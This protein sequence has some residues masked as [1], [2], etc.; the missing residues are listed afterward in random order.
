MIDKIIAILDPLSSPA[1][2]AET[3]RDKGLRTIAA[4]TVDLSPEVLSTFYKPQLFD[5]AVNTHG[6]AEEDV[7]DIITRALAIAAR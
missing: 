5:I 3:L 1:F 2:L 7:V 6:L 4:Y